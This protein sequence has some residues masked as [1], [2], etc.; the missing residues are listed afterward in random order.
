MQLPRCKRREGDLAKFC[1][2]RCDLIGIGWFFPTVPR[3]P[4]SFFLGT[5][6]RKLLEILA[7]QAMLIYKELGDE[8]SAADALK[9]K[10]SGFAE[11]FP[12]VSTLR[13]F[14][15]H[16]GISVN[17]WFAMENLINM[18]LDLGVPLFWNTSIC[19]HTEGF[20]W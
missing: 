7:A 15:C 8:Q 16:W 5:H 1:C 20:L 3:T 12:S 19:V 11:V 14:H 2:W 4:S 10:S 18:D 9:A 17:R 13:G 6:G